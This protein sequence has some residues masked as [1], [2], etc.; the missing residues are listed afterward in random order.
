MKFQHA[1]EFE[2]PP[3]EGERF[4]RAFDDIFRKPDRRAD[5]EEE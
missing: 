5:E 4:R 3:V 1:D 2:L